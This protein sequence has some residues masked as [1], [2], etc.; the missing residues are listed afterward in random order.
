MTPRQRLAWVAAAGF[1]MVFGLGE[2]ARWILESVRGPSWWAID[3]N[4]VLRAG[5]RLETGGQLY[6]DPA[7]L[8]PPAAAVIGAALG[9]LDPFVLSL[10]WAILKLGVVAGAVHRLTP[11]WR[12]GDRV[13][14]AL[15][16]GTCLPFLHDLFLGNVN[17]LLV[18]AVAVAAFGRPSPRSGIALGVLAAVFAK[19]LLLPIGL[20]LLVFRRSTLT[21]T[22]AA[23]LVTT[24]LG[25]VVAGPAAYLAWPGALTGGERFASSF[26]GNHGVSALL[27]EAWLPVAALTGIAL[28][29]VLARR[30]GQIGLVWATTS[31]IL[32]A[33]YAGT[34]SALPIVLAVAVIGPMAPRLALVIV[35]LS[36]VATTYPLPFYAASILGAVLAVREPSAPAGVPAGPPKTATSVSN[37]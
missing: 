17:T 13:P 25:V 15:A 12:P 7:Y 24:A 9:W 30:N 32:I 36:P 35:A 8:Y 2:L 16:V 37:W 4:L 31:G 33:P 11:T 1:V 23:G 27:P 28:L 5:Q 14:A 20:W 29:F 26:A 19:P 21:G 34:Y 22:I 3:L 10:V 18:A 6:S